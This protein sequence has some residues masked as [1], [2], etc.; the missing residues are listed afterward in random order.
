MKA[1]G[2]TAKKKFILA[3][4]HVHF[5]KNRFSCFY[6]TATEIICHQT[7]HTKAMTLTGSQNSAYVASLTNVV[8]T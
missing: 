4:K 1:N 8:W 5:N 6:I 7:S 2:I 3:I